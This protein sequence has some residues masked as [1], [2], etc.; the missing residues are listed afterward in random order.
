MTEFID[1][2]VFSGVAM[3]AAMTG[4]WLISLAL[5][6]SSIVDIFWGTGFVIVTWFFFALT[7]EGLLTRKWLLAGLVTIW[8]VRLSV[9]ILVR[10]WGKGEDFRY[11]AWREAAGRNWWWRSYFKVFL[12]QGVILW[13]LSTP[14]LAGMLSEK[15][16]GA[17]D[18]LGILLWLT[19]FLF[20]AIGD[21]QLVRFKADPANKGKVLESGLWRYSRHPNYFGEAVLWWGYFA[22]AAATGA[23]WT[24]Y[25]PLLMTYLL[26]RVSG[27]AMLER[28]LLQAKPGYAEYIRRT[29]AFVPWFPRK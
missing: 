11:R 5:K 3:F 17:L 27:V 15:P 8:G 25:S 13:L 19:G 14:L 23:Y 2:F 4:L 24:I 18:F 6:D 22:I 9:H 1:I 29:N 12:L 16:L 10:N 21:W 20:E 28:T 7:P 26:L